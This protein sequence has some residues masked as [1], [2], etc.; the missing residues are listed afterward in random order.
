M[1]NGWIGPVGFPEGIILYPT[2]MSS[3][4]HSIRFK[5]RFFRLMS[6]EL[7]TDIDGDHVPWAGTMLYWDGVKCLRLERFLVSPASMSGPRASGPLDQSQAVV[8]LA[9]SAASAVAIHRC[10]FQKPLFD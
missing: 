1:S 5:V 4:R 2:G 10:E 8:Y 7:T 9:I 6:G 3:T